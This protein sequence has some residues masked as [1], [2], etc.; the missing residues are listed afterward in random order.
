MKSE[1]YL[2]RNMLS[3]LGAVLIS[4]IVAMPSQAGINRWTPSLVAVHAN[5]V[6]V[7]ATNPAIAYAATTAGVFKTTDRG[8]QWNLVEPSAAATAIAIDPRDHSR[9]ISGS[10]TEVQVV[11]GVPVSRTTVRLSDNSGATWREMETG[12]LYGPVMTFAFDPGRPGTIY[13]AL[14]ENG[15][16]RT[17]DFGRTWT[18]ANGGLYCCQPNSGFSLT[19]DVAT[20]SRNSTI[21][22]ASESLFRSADAANS[23]QNLDSRPD[24]SWMTLPGGEFEPYTIT[25][26]RVDP[27]RLYMTGWFGP[28]G[29]HPFGPAALTSADDGR[30]WQEFPVAT[31]SRITID[32]R[33]PTMLY[34]TAPSAPR[35][36]ARGVLRSTDRGVT[37]S[38]FNDGLTSLEATSLSMD[39]AGSLLYATTNEGVF[40]YETAVPSRRR[41][42]S[43]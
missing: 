42:V 24:S 10:T 11:D 12:S 33:I 38:E 18:L 3:L 36:D 17:V 1:T 22:A 43:K 27:A 28:Y 31:L 41:A 4:S 25:I 8:V 30:S 15:I 35:Q 20:S 19:H 40:V 21:Y 37:W 39:A 16:V 26:D 32:P 7:D 5:A 2:C 34:T 23:W 13:A 6:V 9:V 29:A 14:L